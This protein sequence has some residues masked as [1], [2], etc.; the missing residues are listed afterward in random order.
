MYI[1]IYIFTYIHIYIY[2][3]I[4]IYALDCL[5]HA[6][7]AVVLR[8]SWSERSAGKSGR[9]HI[10]DG[11]S[12]RRR[13][14]TRPPGWLRRGSYVSGSPRLSSPPTPCILQTQRSLA[15]DWTM[16]GVGGCTPPPAFL[17]TR[18]Y[19]NCAGL[20]HYR[21]TSLIRNRTALGPCC[22]P[23][24]VLGGSAFSYGRGTTVAHPSQTPE[25]RASVP[26][27]RARVWCVAHSLPPGVDLCLGPH[28]ISPS[29]CG[30]RGELPTRAPLPPHTRGARASERGRERAREREREIEREGERGGRFPPPGAVMV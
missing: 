14:G 4:S 6:G 24:G 30:G 13:P 7:R 3:H 29:R 23:R 22:S 18:P 17:C 10:G 20:P 2:I 8:A 5:T 1:H 9:L 11:A 19:A 27:R 21:G 12:A 28:N 16:H 25:C 15:C 26:P